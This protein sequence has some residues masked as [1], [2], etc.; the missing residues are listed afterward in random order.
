MGLLQNNVLVDLE[1]NI[2]ET[3]VKM[4]PGK[5]ENTYKILLSFEVY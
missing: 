1:G 2:A 3:H 4:G 5:M